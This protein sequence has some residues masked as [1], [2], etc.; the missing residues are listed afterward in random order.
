M[1]ASPCVGD[2]KKASVDFTDNSPAGLSALNPVLLIESSRVGEH[3]V[4]AQKTDPVLTLV[5][6]VLGWIPFEVEHL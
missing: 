2:E 1:V 6:G 4:C 3:R 5:G